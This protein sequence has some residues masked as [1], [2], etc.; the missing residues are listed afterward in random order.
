MV[1][2]N[3]RLTPIMRMRV[4]EQSEF[5]RHLKMLRESMIFFMQH[6]SRQLIVSC[7]KQRKIRLFLQTY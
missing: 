1:E 6:V 2:L 7:L 3:D 5:K 4:N